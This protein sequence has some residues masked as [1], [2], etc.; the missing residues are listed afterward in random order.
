MEMFR[1]LSV[2]CFSGRENKQNSQ[3]NIWTALSKRTKGMGRRARR[4]CVLA[5]RV[6]NNQPE[7]RLAPILSHSH[8]HRN[9]QGPRVVHGG[10]FNII[11]FNYSRQLSSILLQSE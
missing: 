11:Y 3:N 4:W 10:D 2:S 6:R 5:E 8:C 1:C 9:S 7:D